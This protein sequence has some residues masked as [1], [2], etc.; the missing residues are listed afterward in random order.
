[1]RGDLWLSML[2]MI[3]VSTRGDAEHVSG[4]GLVV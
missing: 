2:V 4:L 1:M 3:P